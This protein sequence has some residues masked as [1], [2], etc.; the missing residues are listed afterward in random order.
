VQFG[1]SYTWARS[2]DDGSSSTFGDTFINSVSSLPAWAPKRRKALSDFNVNTN[3]VVNW[4]YEFSKV[5]SGNLASYFINGWQWGGIFQYSTGVPFTPLISGDPLRLNGA[6][7]FAFPDRLTGPGCT[8]N[9]VNSQKK[10]YVKTQCFAFPPFDPVTG[11]TR[12]GNA[13]RNSIYGPNLANL[14]NSFTKNTR[15]P[16]ICDQCN[17]QFRTEIFNLLNRSNYATPV[18]VGTQLF[19]ATGA[20]LGGQAGQLNATA[21]SSRQIQFGVKI[22]F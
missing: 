10:S 20:A 16:N 17:L 11:F 9:P 2:F 4:L 15:F 1:V 21:T 8:G 14:D 6:D 18:K 12:L 7:N 22:I 5:R 13:G 19:S 3:I